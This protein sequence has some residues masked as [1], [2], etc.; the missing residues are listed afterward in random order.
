[1]KKLSAGLAAAA[2]AIGIGIVAVSAAA[3]APATWP[4]TQAGEPAAGRVQ[5]HGALRAQAVQRNLQ[6]DRTRSGRPHHALLRQQPLLPELPSRQRHAALRI[7]GD[8]RVRRVPHLHGARRRSP[9]VRRAH[10]GLHGAQHERPRAPARRQGDEGVPRLYPVCQHGHPGRQADRWD[11][12]RRRC[13][14]RSRGRSRA[15]RTMCTTRTVRVSSGGRTRTAQWR[16]GRREGLSLSAA[17]GTRQLQQRRGHAP[18][19]R[20]GQLHSRQHAV[21]HAL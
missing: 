13:H 2:L 21:R 7:A 10:P 17:L 20:V 15:R 3:Q 14:A 11:A 19:D 1:M 8:R 6:R 4:A 18:L 16:R 9:H 5:G 12:G